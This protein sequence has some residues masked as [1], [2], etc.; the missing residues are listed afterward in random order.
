MSGTCAD[1]DTQNNTR[2]CDGK[3]ACAAAST[4]DCATGYACVTYQGGACS[5]SCGSDSDCTSNYF[6]QYWTAP[7]NSCQPRKANG[8]TCSNFSNTE[9]ASGYCVDGVCCDKACNG[10]CEGC[11][12]ALTGKT[13][14]TCSFIP[15]GQASGSDCSTQNASTCGQTGVCDGMCACAKIASGTHCGRKDWA[16]PVAAPNKVTA[17]RNKER[18][19]IKVRP[20]K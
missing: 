14:G 6:C 12:N 13:N 15:N 10:A 3:G 19:L 18:F 4:T 2:S 7:L 5:T 16:K 20:K 11:S 8:K 17:S 1:G 9:C